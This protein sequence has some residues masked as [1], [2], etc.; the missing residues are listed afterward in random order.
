[1]AKCN[2]LIACVVCFGLLIWFIRMIFLFSESKMPIAHI[3]DFYIPALNT[4]LPNFNSTTT[5]ANFIFFDLELKNE[6]KEVGVRYHNVDLT[7]YYSTPKP[8]LLS[9]VHYTIPGFYQGH[10]K[11]AHRCD[12]VETRGMPWLDAFAAVSNGSTVVFTVE[13][14]TA[15]KL[16]RFFGSYSKTKQLLLGADVEVNGYGERVQKKSI[17]L[18]E[19]VPKRVKDMAA[20]RESD[21]NLRV[22]DSNASVYSA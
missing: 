14:F 7:F 6:M 17:K 5:T 12:V 4:K 21:L 8:S 2:P 1:M 15:V 13:L 11:A 9:I 18:K 3:Q 19:R 16:K 10:D 20:T 22:A